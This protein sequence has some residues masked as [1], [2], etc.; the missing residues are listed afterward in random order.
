MGNI[1]NLH[2]TGS[3]RRPCEKTHSKEATS[4]VETLLQEKRLKRLK[5]IRSRLETYINQLV[6]LGFNSAKYDVVLI[7]KYLQ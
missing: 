1:R 2:E 3:R 7:K 4:A 5:G 6:V